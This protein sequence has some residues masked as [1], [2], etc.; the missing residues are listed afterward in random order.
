M[1]YLVGPVV[2]FLVSIVLEGLR[3]WWGKEDRA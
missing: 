2:M 1:K 3:E